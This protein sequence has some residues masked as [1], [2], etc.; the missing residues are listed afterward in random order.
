MIE[1]GQLT[2]SMIQQGEDTENKSILTRMTNALDTHWIE[3]IS[4]KGHDNRISKPENI[5]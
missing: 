5:L 4:C 2:L 3:N 1:T